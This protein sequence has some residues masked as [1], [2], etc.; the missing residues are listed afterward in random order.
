M[1]LKSIVNLF[2]LL[3]LFIPHQ[4]FNQNDATRIIPR[5][6]KVEIKKINNDY[7]LYRDGEPYFIKGASGF[8]YY[9]RIKKYGGNSIRIW[10]SDNAQ[11][12]LNQADSIGLTVTLGLFI[13]AQRF[14]FDYNN[15]EM[16]EKQKQYVK[17]QIIKYKDYP[18][19]LMWGIGNE[20]ELGSTD[21]KFWEAIDSIA[22][23]IHEI[24]PN[25]PT[26]TMLAGVQEKHV[27]Y[28]NENVRNLDILSINTFKD[29][30]NV[31][32][33]IKQAGWTR[34][35]LISEWGAT[36]YWESEQ[37]KWNVFIEETSTEKAALC[38][39]RYES[40]IKKDI[41]QCIGSYIFLW[42]TKQERTH[43]L[44][45][46]FLDS[47][48]ET[49]LTDVLQY[50]WKGKLPDNRCPQINLFTIEGST[51]HDNNYLQSNYYYHADAKCIDFENELLKYKWE[52][53]SESTDLKI[54]TEAEGKPGVIPDLICEQHGEGIYFKA[55][56][57]EGAYRLFI[58]VYDTDNN[59]ATANIPFYVK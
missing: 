21:F 6:K 5:I 37:T 30:P 48:L 40:S 56:L 16:V 45:S 46:L 55:P 32:Y 41:S 7:R 25:H 9:D 4:A 57:N 17:Q 38:Q 11:N 10:N 43:T 54:G 24:D 2:L 28:L 59:V 47:G 23:M 12:V 18:A 50:L 14:G 29:L 3:I 58:Y 39:Q 15:P 26:T 35:Y 22:R 31:P 13:G 44:F 20:V 49:E 33:K 51:S 27:K 52:I 1:V 53:L 34:P 42:G 36:G 8:S 19:L